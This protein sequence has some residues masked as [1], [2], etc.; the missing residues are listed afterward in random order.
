MLGCE[1]SAI[2]N[3]NKKSKSYKI[4]MHHLYYELI[5]MCFR[6]TNIVGSGDCPV[7]LFEMRISWPDIHKLKRR[8]EERKIHICQFCTLLSKSKSKCLLCPQ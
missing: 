2:E 1:S 7:E 8:E 6:T 4:H 3:F 5:P